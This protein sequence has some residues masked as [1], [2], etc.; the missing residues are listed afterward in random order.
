[1]K[2][3]LPR[4]YRYL[5]EM[6]HACFNLKDGEQILKYC[7]LLSR[8]DNRS[9]FIWYDLGVTY[10][11][12]IKEYE[13][14]ILAFEKV[15]EIDRE[16]GQNW[17]Y[18][19]YY[20]WYIRSLHEAGMYKKAQE[21]S[22]QGLLVFPDHVWLTRKRLS[23]ALLRADSSEIIEFSANIERLRREQEWSEAYYEHIFVRIYW[24]AGQ[25]EEAEKHAIRAHELEPGNTQYS[26][27]LSWIQVIYDLNVAEGTRLMLEVLEIEPDDIW[28]LWIAGTGLRKL[29]K[30]EEALQIFGRKDDIDAGYF[31][32]IEEEI[33][34]INDIQAQN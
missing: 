12:M 5:V 13:K 6:W 32:E 10:G 3:N 7:D 4:Y 27:D 16:K 11:S 30:L 21:I 1:M 17:N 9:R 31:H 23:N 18:L 28:S 34:F 25:F 14:S 24:G 33:K 15:E 29:G 20:R 8:S 26:K 22:D 2:E 19:P